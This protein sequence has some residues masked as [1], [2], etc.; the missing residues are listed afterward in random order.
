M[1]I[2]K[3]LPCQLKNNGGYDSVMSHENEQ[4]SI[5]GITCFFCDKVNK[6]LCS[7]L[8]IPDTQK[9][10]MRNLRHH[11]FFAT[12]IYLELIVVVV[13]DKRTRF[14]KHIRQLHFPDLPIK[15]SCLNVLDCLLATVNGT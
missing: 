1:F 15:Q 13:N 11:H 4:G 8:G 3:L 10:L 12:W 5:R 2:V 9:F 14:A 7:N 6:H